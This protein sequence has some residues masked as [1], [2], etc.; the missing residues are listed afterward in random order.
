MLSPPCA[1]TC[2]GGETGAT[3]RLTAVLTLTEIT[4]QFVDLFDAEDGKGC[5]VGVAAGVGDLVWFD[6]EHRLIADRAD[7]EFGH[8][9]LPALNWQGPQ[10]PRG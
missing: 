7:I 3:V 9:A 10:V 2:S 4:D 1:L 6:C 5:V 8:A